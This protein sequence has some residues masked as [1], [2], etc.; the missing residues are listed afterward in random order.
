MVV[1]TISRSEGST[2]TRMLSKLELAGM[3]ALASAVPLSAAAQ[4][5]SQ[6]E[7]QQQQSRAQS[8]EGQGQSQGREASQAGQQANSQAESQAEQ[9]A[10][11]AG[12]DDTQV[13]R[14][15]DQS[16][17]S[18]EDRPNPFAR[19]DDS[20]ISISGT[21]SEIQPLSLIHI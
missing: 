13:A 10:R 20:W 5:Q 9:G 2:R 21:V 1:T 16:Q 4:D 19:A 6:R 12:Q 14:A 18:A 11:E 17:S 3:L 7:S 15:D 8:E